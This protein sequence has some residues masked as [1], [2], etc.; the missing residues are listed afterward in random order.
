[1][2]AVMSEAADTRYLVL[3]RPACQV[4]HRLHACLAPCRYREFL[5]A[6][7]LSEGYTREEVVE[8]LQSVGS[9]L[10]ADLGRELEHAAHMNFLVL[11]QVFQQVERIG[12]HFTIDTSQLEDAELLKEMRNFELAQREVDQKISFGPSIRLPLICEHHV[13]CEELRARHGQLSSTLMSR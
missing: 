10:K 4:T 3:C 6:R 2:D 12:L 5:V 7:L 1:M 9:I 11:Q 8:L 13:L